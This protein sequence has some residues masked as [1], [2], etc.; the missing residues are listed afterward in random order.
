MR[1]I[2][3]VLGLLFV[4]LIVGMLTKKQ[5]AAVAPAP[6]ATVQGV[7]LPTLPQSAA[8]DVKQSLDAIMQQA[9]PA[10]EEK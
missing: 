7:A 2:F 3:G 1:I 4:V 8:S 9:R 5:L 10:L 6:A